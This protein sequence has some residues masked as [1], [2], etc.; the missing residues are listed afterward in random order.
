MNAVVGVHTLNV[1]EASL[2]SN[3]FPVKDAVLDNCFAGYEA[4]VSA[5][6]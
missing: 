1:F 6:F 4:P 5:P 3:C 2:G